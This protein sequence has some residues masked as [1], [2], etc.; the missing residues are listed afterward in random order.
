MDKKPFV[1]VEISQVMWLLA[2]LLKSSNVLYIKEFVRIERVLTYAE[3]KERVIMELVNVLK[4]ME[5]H[6]VKLNVM[7]LALTVLGLHWLNAL[8]VLLMELYQHYQMEHADALL[9]REEIH[10]VSYVRLA[11]LTVLNVST[12]I[13]ARINTVFLT[14]SSEMVFANVL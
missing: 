5:D 12:V 14:K 13:S 7:Q 11:L 2:T 8:L 3:E 9:E 4:D 10:L 6:L 1:M